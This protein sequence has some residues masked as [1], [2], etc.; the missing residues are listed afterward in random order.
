MVLCMRVLNF[1]LL[2]IRCQT[3]YGNISNRT[4]TLSNQQASYDSRSYAAGPAFRPI[5]SY[6]LSNLLALFFLL[7]HLSKNTR[8]ASKY[9]YLAATDQFC[10]S[11]DKIS[12]CGG[13]LV[14][15]YFILALLSIS[16]RQ[17]SN[18][19]FA[20]TLISRFFDNLHSKRGQIYRRH[21]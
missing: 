8:S 13:D 6:R 4:F 18:R 19:Q 11:R 1:L 21:F 14:Q 9:D 17:G 7:A 10:H 5:F 16:Y 20:S 12:G 3:V 15:S 2:Y